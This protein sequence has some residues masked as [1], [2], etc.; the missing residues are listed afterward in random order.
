MPNF[1]ISYPLTDSDI[2]TT[3]VAYGPYSAIRTW[4]LLIRLGLDGKTEEPEYKLW[5]QLLDKEKR[6]E[7]W[8]ALL[9]RKE[10]ALKTSP[11]PEFLRLVALLPLT[12][13]LIRKIAGGADET[14]GDP[15]TAT[16]YCS[17]TKWSA[18]MPSSGTCG[19]DD[20]S[21]HPYVYRF[22]AS[23]AGGL[24]KTSTSLAV[25][26]T[27]IASV[28]TPCVS[29][30]SERSRTTAP[31]ELLAKSS[32]A[33]TY[34]PRVVIADYPRNP[35]VTAATCT[36][37]RI[38]AHNKPVFIRALSATPIYGRCEF[39]VPIPD[40]A[41]AVEYFAE[42]LLLSETGRVIYT[43]RESLKQL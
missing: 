18:A 41:K 13:T 20:G 21:G 23:L 8:V 11:S 10:E 34:P 14:V 4:L 22:V 7:A 43:H 30:S 36:V 32:G 39:L 3:F 42:A 40:D 6:I 1:N 26:S 16:I 38:D 2:A 19:V 27:Q 9:K 29:E 37:Y 28:A 24:P 25:S 31:E 15:V 35:Y 33:T 17:E 5:V 12:C